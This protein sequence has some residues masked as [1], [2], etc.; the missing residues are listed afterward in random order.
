MIKENRQRITAVNTYFNDIIADPS[1]N[2][3]F[4]LSPQEVAAYQIA[5]GGE[6]SIT[7]H[8]PDDIQEIVVD[9]TGERTPTI[10]IQEV[11]NGTYGEST[12]KNADN[13]ILDGSNTD[14]LFNAANSRYN[15]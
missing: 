3:D 13:Q 10:I 5:V 15:N 1:T 6:L 14:A 2:A 11:N 9:A 12:F 8:D 7:G 4:I